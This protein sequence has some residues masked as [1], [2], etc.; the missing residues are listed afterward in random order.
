MKKPTNIQDNGFKTP[1]NYFEN[2]NHELETRMIEENLKERFGNKNPFTVP[3]NYFLNFSVHLNRTKKSSGK[4]IQ[5]LKPYLSI[6]AGIIIMFG[7]WQILLTNID[8]S[9]HVA[10][11]I[12]T[13]TTNNTVLLSDNT[14]N[15]D[16]VEISDLNEQFETYI[17]E[18]DATALFVYTEEETESFEIDATEEEIYDYLMD[19]A[20]DEDYAEI[21]ASL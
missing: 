15:L 7:I 4:V 13:I 11:K 3:K 12:D 9:E 17:D 6:A 10:G 21:L 2:F 14:L 8:S 18:S 20:D 5:M 16:D 1:E 19:Y